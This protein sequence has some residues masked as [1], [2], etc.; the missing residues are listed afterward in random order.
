MIGNAWSFIFGVMYVWFFLA[1][2]GAWWMM[3][4]TLIRY[5]SSGHGKSMGKS[6]WIR[7]VLVYLAYLPLSSQVARFITLHRA[8]EDAVVYF[9]WLIPAL[10]IAGFWYKKKFEAERT[11]PSE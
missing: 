1:F 10:V 4:E 5:S 3:V 2:F 11:Q 9:V 6:F 8:Y 7:A